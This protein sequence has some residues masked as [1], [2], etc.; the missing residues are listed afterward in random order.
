[1]DLSPFG[2]I[3]CVSGDGVVHEVL[4][5]MMHRH[6][7]GERGI[8]DRPIAVLAAGSGNGLA[9]TFNAMDPVTSTYA[10][11]NGVGYS[12]FQIMAI[13]PDDAPTRY[14]FLNL[15]WGIV[16]AIDCLSCSG[17]VSDK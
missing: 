15:N 3:L 6:L 11:L 5:A 12:R 17:N 9:A 16:S 7:G 8:L 14:S 10:L 4:Q 1:M 13:T 2:A